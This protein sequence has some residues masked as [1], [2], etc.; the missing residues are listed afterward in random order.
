MGRKEIEDAGM[1]FQGP[2]Q[3]MAFVSS[4]YLPFVKT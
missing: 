4:I 2:G 1:Y 3:E